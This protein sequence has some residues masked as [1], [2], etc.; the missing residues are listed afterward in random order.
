MPYG[1]LPYAAVV[2]PGPTRTTSSRLLVAPRIPTFENV[3]LMY[4]V[5]ESTYVPGAR[6]IVVLDV[7][8]RTAACS[9]GSVETFTTA[10]DGAAR[11]GGDV[12]VLACAV[13]GR[14]SASARA[15]GIRMAGREAR[16]IPGS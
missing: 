11:G 8:L 2:I 14:M 10:P 15:T 1:V 9:C 12:V 5:L 3:P 4:N 16:P 13:T 7:R 6:T